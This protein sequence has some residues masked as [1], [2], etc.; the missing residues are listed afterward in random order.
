M[1]APAGSSLADNPAGE[2]DRE[3][4]ACSLVMDAPLV[5][6]SAEP[7]APPGVK[8]LSCHQCLNS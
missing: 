1:T 8:W 3:N 6:I 4:M 2:A 5:W 7:A